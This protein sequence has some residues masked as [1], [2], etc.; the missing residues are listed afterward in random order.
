VSRVKRDTAIVSNSPSSILGKSRLAQQRH[1]V[2]LVFVVLLWLVAFA[3]H[4]HARDDV[5]AGSNGPSAAC[6]FCLSLPAGAA[7][8]VVVQL[9]APVLLPGVVVV[10]PSVPLGSRDVP[11]FYLSR[12]PPAP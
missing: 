9:V 4:A 5:A 1:V 7:P 3:S 6:S 12:A 2:A 11:S 8:P 10:Q